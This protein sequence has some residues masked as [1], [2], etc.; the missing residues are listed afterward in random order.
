MGVA[1]RCLWDSVLATG[2]PVE[3]GDGMPSD[4]KD[5]RDTW[6]QPEASKKAFWSH[7]LL[8]NGTL[9]KASVN[10]GVM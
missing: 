4:S 8:I 1:H 3:V 10:S 9:Y 6:S 2:L 7:T 5:A